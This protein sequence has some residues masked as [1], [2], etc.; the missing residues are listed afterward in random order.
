MVFDPQE[1]QLQIIGTQDKTIMHKGISPRKV[2][3]Y[4]WYSPEVATGIFDDII[5]PY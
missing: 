2:A 1:K 5:L 4:D 3:T